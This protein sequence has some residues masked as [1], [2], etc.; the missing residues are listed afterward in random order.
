[1]KSNILLSIVIP[2]YNEEKNIAN[3][4]KSISKQSIVKNI[5][6]II[7]NDNSDDRTMDVIKKMAS[8]AV[9]SIICTTNTKK[10]GAMQCRLQGILLSHAPHILFADADDIILGTGSLEKALLLAQKNHVDILHCHTISVIKGTGRREEIDWTCPIA[11]KLNK[12]EL[13]SAFFSTKLY[14]PIHLWAKIFSR[15]LLLDVYEQAKD[16]NIYRFD[17][18]FLM[19]L[20]TYYANS[21]MQCN[22]YIYQYQY[23]NEMCFERYPARIHDFCQIIE[24]MCPLLNKMDNLDAKNAYISFLKRRISYNVGKFCLALE[25]DI[26]TE[27]Y[28]CLFNWIGQYISMKKFYNVLLFSIECNLAKIKKINNK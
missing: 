8:K 6:V 27:R 21:Y 14:P 3:I 19:S 13:F 20:A 24:I 26:K 5:E 2:V 1:M 4:L 11:K 25:D 22:E 10:S 16:I 17:D 9:H 28:D 12:K 15:K 18:K 7:V 23:R